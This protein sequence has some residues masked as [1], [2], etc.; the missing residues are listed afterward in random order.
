MVEIN[1]RQSPQTLVDEGPGAEKH[2]GRETWTASSCLDPGDGICPIQR[3]EA[4]WGRKAKRRWPRKRQQ[5]ITRRVMF[6]SWG[7]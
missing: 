1:G 7:R 4:D 3:G 5:N 6:R 2:G